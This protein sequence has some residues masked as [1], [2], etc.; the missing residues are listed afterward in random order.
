M[1]VKDMYRISINKA[2]SSK[3]RIARVKAIHKIMQIDKH[4]QSYDLKKI[5]SCTSSSPCR[6]M[7]CIHCSGG[8]PWPRADGVLRNPVRRHIKRRAAK[9]TYIRGKGE[10]MTECFGYLDMSHVSLVR[11]TIK[12]M[13]IDEDP[14]TV[15]SKFRKDLYQF[16]KLNI[17]DAVLR[18]TAEIA[19]NHANARYS[20]YPN[21]AVGE[22][23]RASGFA[24]MPAH[25]LHLHG[26]L[27]HPNLNVGQVAN[28]FHSFIPGT[29]RF[30][31]GKPK[32]QS[33]DEDGNE[34][35]GAV[36][37]GEYSGLE[38]KEI[39]PFVPPG[40]S[41]GRVDIAAF[42]AHDLDNYSL[43]R[44]LLPQYKKFSRSKRNYKFNDR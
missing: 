10:W 18:G 16:L 22:K 36:G 30:W 25:N 23:I 28:L 7:G 11:I 41:G 12:I 29:D 27:Y 21:D 3:D 2:L 15:N 1:S 40:Y 14:C 35:G 42:Q 8:K 20:T 24:N 39:T 43:V 13:D 17:P 26:I 19:I 32:A 44:N 5:R 33:T 9:G 34:L 31:I 6:R 38:I 4:A 37:W